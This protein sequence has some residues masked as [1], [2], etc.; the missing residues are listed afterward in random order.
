[1]VDSL[2]ASGQKFGIPVGNNEVFPIHFAKITLTIR[3]DGERAGCYSKSRHGG[4]RA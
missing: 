2:E 1:M 4:K 3:G